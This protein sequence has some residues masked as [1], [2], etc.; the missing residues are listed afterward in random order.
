MRKG[1]SI[2]ELLVAMTVFSIVLVGFLAL[3]TSAF[4]EQKGSLN[5][6]YLLNN[7]SYIS[8]YITRAVRMARKELATPPDCLPSFGLNYELTRG[9]K[10][11][12]FINYLGE[13]QEFYLENNILKVGKPSGVESLTP[14]DIRV[15]DLNFVLSGEDQ[16]DSLQPKVT[17]ALKMTTVQAP[18]KSFDLQLTISQRA[19]DVE[20]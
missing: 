10:G 8:E 14:S 19:L 12:K 7:S 11:L 17:F 2:T 6:S 16:A 13:C 18:A 4:Q 15:D 20:Y 9:G 5:V 3:F 1:F